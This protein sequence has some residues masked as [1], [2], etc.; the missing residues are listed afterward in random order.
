MIRNL[1]SSL[2]FILLA[3][4]LSAGEPK[5]L[6]AARAEYKQHPGEAARSAYILRLMKLRGEF[7]KANKTAEWKAVDAEII[8]NPVPQGADS[9]ALSNLLVGKWQSPQNDFLYKKDGTWTMLPEAPGVASG[10][11][12][13]DGNKI[14]SWMTFDPN[15]SRTMTLILLDDKLFICADKGKIFFDMRAAK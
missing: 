3:S 9:A 11:W 1:V 13:I 14:S 7:G 12:R 15:K 4:T 2:L 6:T 5:E 8:R 10:R